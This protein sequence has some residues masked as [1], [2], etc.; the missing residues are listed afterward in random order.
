MLYFFENIARMDLRDKFFYL[1]ILWISAAYSGQM[2]NDMIVTPG[3]N[4]LLINFSPNHWDI[5]K[6]DGAHFPMDIYSF[7]GAAFP[8]EPGSPHIPCRSVTIGIPQNGEIGIEIIDAEFVQLNNSFIA[9]V[10]NIK[11]DEGILK[12]AYLQ[13]PNIYQLTSFYPVEVVKLESP[14]FFRSQRVVQLI[15]YPLQFRPDLRQVRQYKRI[16]VR[17]NFSGGEI[18]QSKIRP[19]KD[20][21]LYK[22]LLVNYRQ[23]Q[24]W[25]VKQKSALKRYKKVF[26]GQDWYKV[27]IEGNGRGGKQGIYKIGGSG[28]ASAGINLS[29]VDAKTIQMFC[30]SRQ[31]NVFNTYTALPDSLVEIPIEV[32]DGEDGRFGSGDYIL[33]Y[34]SS[35]EG[36]KFETT[37]DS[38]RV[39]LRHFIHPFSFENVYWLTYGKKTGKRLAVQKSLDINGLTPEKSFRDLIFIEDERTNL[40]HS[41]VNWFGFELAPDKDSY[42]QNVQLPGAV[43][44]GDA[45][46]RFK[47]ALVTDTDHGLEFFFNGFRLGTVKDDGIWGGYKALELNYPTRGMLADGNNTVQID[48]TVNSGYSSAYVDWI[49]IEYDRAFQAKEN[50]LLFRS[51]LR[52]GPVNYAISGFSEN[53]RIFEITDMSE[54]SLI[55][56]AAVQDGMV[57]FTAPARI[58]I[59]RSYI[60]VTPAAYRAVSRIEKDQTTDLHRPREVDYIIITH[61]NFKKPAEELASLRENWSTEDRLE[62]EVVNISDVID[63]F[64]GGVQDPAVIKSFLTFAQENWGQPAYVLLLGDGHYDYKNILNYDTPNLIPPYESADRYESST[65]TTDDWF[66]YTSGYSAGMQIAIGRLPARNIEEAQYMVDKIVAYE[67]KPDYG[68]WRKTI[69][70]VADDE[71]SQ[72]G[73]ENEPEHT[74][75]AETLADNFTPDFFNINKIYLVDY[76]VVRTASVAGRR[77]PLASETILEQINRGTIIFNFIGHANDELLSHEQVLY[78]PT[79]FDRIQ[80]GGKTA[81]WVVASCEFAYWD[82]P[83]EES[84]GEKIMTAAG[85][86]AV[87]M[88]AS[89]RVAYGIDNAPLNCNLYQHLFS[90]LEFSGKTARIGDAV[91]LAKKSYSNRVNNEKYILLGDPAMRLCVPYYRVVIEHVSPDSISALTKMSI[92]GSVRKDSSLWTGLDASVLVRVLD[93]E[94][95]RTYVTAKNTKIDYTIAGNSIFRG[96]VKINDGRFNVYF[97]VPKDISYG[98][99]NGKISLYFWNEFYE[100]AGYRCGLPVGGTAVNLVDNDGPDI[101]LHFGEQ[102]FVSGDYC[103]PNPVLHVQ[104]TDSLSGVNI[105]GDI[106]H[107]ITLTLDEDYV[108]TCD[109]TEYFQYNQGSYVTGQLKYPMHELS[110]GLHQICLKAWDNSNN[111]AICE[112]YVNVVADQDLRIRN[113]LNHP[114]PMS[115]ETQ[116]CFELSRDAQVRIKIYTL[117]G[118]I[119]KEFPPV[120][121]HIGF[122]I[123]PDKWDGRDDDGDRM[124]NGVY[125]YKLLARKTIDGENKYA[126]KIGKLVLAN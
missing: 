1:F 19:Q 13:D 53:V 92:K 24:K 15:F 116:F 89:S 27:F 90:D 54:A 12:K 110:E 107:Q 114:N 64:G 21:N 60:A 2:K 121:G 51:P 9:P 81:F 118:K 58:D 98:G 18:S 69:T 73:T 7:D 49:E 77:K 28:L 93:S 36:V 45:E 88:F 61:D 113:L 42:S 87:A 5:K 115:E 125:L 30:H 47:L 40:Y 52:D 4:Q 105:A 39:K 25:R 22:N 101:H 6:I 67:T 63:E 104:I 44:S 84:L 70:I 17:I 14:A 56:G 26:S 65:R 94:N 8:G 43:T 79:D 29:G 3:N 57:N 10:A 123:Y 50:Q 68:E 72:T 62:T 96:V 111:S 33:F 97:I 86:G 74:N 117:G 80:N 126:E 108:N 82:Q 11:R 100:G 75:Q 103:S 119:V 59:P 37:Y 23:A 34:G 71:L 55:T 85:R 20:E 122:N 31:L 109:I 46:V 83:D 38:T 99:T 35:L 112:T 102:D 16:A 48:Y 41:G 32:V 106:G 66:T 91:L 78:G 124:A 95:H 76:P 120:S